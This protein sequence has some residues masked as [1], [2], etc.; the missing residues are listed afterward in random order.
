MCKD[1]T[2]EA[3]SQLKTL[4]LRGAGVERVCELRPFLAH[5]SPYVVA[6]AVKIALE[7]E[8]ADLSADLSQ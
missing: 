8:L 1:P 4:E 7:M 6:R 2:V 3:L 5:R